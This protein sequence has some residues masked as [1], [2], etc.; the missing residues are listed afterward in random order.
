M[1]M[2]ISSTSSADNFF[3]EKLSCFASFNSNREFIF[4]LPLNIIVSIFLSF[5]KAIKKINIDV[6]TG[7]PEGGKGLGLGAGVKVPGGGIS[8]PA[9]SRQMSGRETGG[10]QFSQEIIIFQHKKCAIN[11]L[12]LYILCIF[13]CVKSVEF[14]YDPEKSHSNKIKHGLD[15]EEAKQLWD[16]PFR[17]VIKATTVDE[18]RWIM[19]ARLTGEYWSV[20]FT[21]RKEVIR[22][23][24]VRK[25]RENEKAIYKS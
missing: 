16:D 3:A 13:A 18:E 6:V 17:V 12:I 10:R 24:S 14:E 23:I 25:S 20:I 1:A 15:F 4:E 22:I 19:V 8:L 9:L 21:T 5:Y 2:P 7:V 11:V